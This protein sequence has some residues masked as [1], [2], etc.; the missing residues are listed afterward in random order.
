MKCAYCGKPMSAKGHGGVYQEIE[1]SDPSRGK[2]W[3]GWHAPYGKE[4]AKEEEFCYW[5]DLARVLKGDKLVE[6]LD[7]RG[8]GRVGTAPW[9]G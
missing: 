8:R 1:T 2:V 9:I 5:R 6:E 7:G 3:V 4:D